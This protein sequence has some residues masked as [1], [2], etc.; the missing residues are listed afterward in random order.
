M[1]LKQ[2]LTA[3]A[4]LWRASMGDVGVLIVASQE[5]PERWEAN[6]RAMDRCGERGDPSGVSVWGG[7]ASSLLGWSSRPGLRVAVLPQH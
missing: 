6:Q 5:R 7:W 2:G 4:L 1:D 3:V